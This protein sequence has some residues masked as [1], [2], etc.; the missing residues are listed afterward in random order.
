M[1][2]SDQEQ[3]L[4]QHI[5]HRVAACLACLPLQEQL[6]PS[7]ADEETR[8]QIRYKFFQNAAWEG[9]MAGMR[10]LIE[11]VGVAAHPN[12]EP[13]PPKRRKTDVSIK[14]IQGGEEIDLDSS[15]AATLAKVWQGCAQASG[16]PTQDS[17]HPPVDPA[18]L[19]EAMKIIIG[20]LERTIYKATDRNLVA[21]TFVPLP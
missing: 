5:P 11:F 18:A 16:H 14:C 19:N 8:G 20:H 13:R 6:M 15:E 10:W 2:P 21:Q 4:V 9:R 1:N 3:W 12:G 7:A 17:N